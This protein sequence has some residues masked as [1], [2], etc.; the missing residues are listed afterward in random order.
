MQ[1]TTA[2]LGDI[3]LKVDLLQA[4]A[5]ARSRVNY[6]LNGLIVWRE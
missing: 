1:S 2:Q 4:L 3:H 5:E 6:N